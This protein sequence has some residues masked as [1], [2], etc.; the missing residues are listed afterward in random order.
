MMQ[1]RAALFAATVLAVPLALAGRA[2]AQPV[3]G[4]YVSLGGGYSL[5]SQM[6]AKNFTF[7]GASVPGDAKGVFHNGY[8]VNGAIGY[9]FGNG[10]RV[11]LEGDYIR[12]G[13]NKVKSAGTTTT[14]SGNE[15]RYGAFI[16]G[17]FDFDVG[18]P[19]LYPYAG[20]G[21]GWQNVSYNNI[22]GGGLSLNQSRDSLAYQG[23]VGL[24]F[25]IAP[26]MG[27]SA[28]VEY[29]FIGLATARRYDA[30]IGGVPA[31]FKT[32]GEYNNQFNVGLRYEFA[33][34]APPAPPPA[35]APV[36]APAPAPAKTYLV[37]FDWDKYNLTPR[38]TQIIALAASDSKT[39]NVT[40]LKVNGYTDTSGAAKYN[41]GLSIKRAKA[42]AAQLV[43][44]GV[45]ASEIEIHGFGETH[46]LVPTGPGVREPQNRRVEIIFD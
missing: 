11:E 29:R 44:D 16:N 38:A 22:S 37:F 39:Q 34:P 17:I 12:N 32:Q 15:A 18:L 6:T 20:A 4:P 5:E 35:P 25:P 9:G 19:W 36:A 45:P 8:D 31:T 10:W 28:T 1:F 42:V 26:V 23:I 43:A 40:T 30:S 41:M 13:A 46:L 33:P 14:L 7:N 27:L 21:L 3:T 24:S 2:A